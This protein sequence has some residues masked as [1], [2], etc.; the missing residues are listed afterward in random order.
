MGLRIVPYG[1]NSDQPVTKAQP[2]KELLG[3]SYE[4]SWKILWFGA[5]YPWFNIRILMDAI[6]LL[7][8][9]HPTRLIMV[10][11]KNPFNAHPDFVAKSEEVQSLVAEPEFKDLIQTHDWVPFESRADWYLDCD[12]IITLNEPGMENGLSWRTRVADYVWAGMPVASNGGDPLT[13]DLIAH[14]GASRV[15][16]GSAESLSE[17][18]HKILSDEA[19]LKGMKAQMQLYRPKLYWENVIKPL[20][21]IIECHNLA[22]DR[23]S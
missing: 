21:K 23:I 3:G 16:I 11:A 12:L 7:N 8:Q 22:A 4:K 20:G 5:V 18:I 9:K 1:I 17:S 2:I 14:G 13:E 6:Q 19:R 10:G 15:D